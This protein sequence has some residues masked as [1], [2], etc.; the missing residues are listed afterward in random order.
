[1]EAVI[2]GNPNSGSA[3]DEGYLEHF[4]GI[5]REG[6]LQV[7]VLNTEHPDHATELAASSSDKLVIAA[8]GDGTINEV[9]NGL[10]TGATFGVLPLG[11]ANVLA[12][13][14]GLPLDPEQACQTILTGTASRM[15][16]GIATDQEGTERRFALMAG[17]GFDAEVVRAVTP[18]VK[19][20]LRG[21]AYPLMALKVYF[22]S[23]K[24]EL[25]VKVG[26]TN[27][28]TE[29]AVIANG[30]YYGGDFEIAEDTSLRSGNIEVVLI[31][32]V[33]FLLRVDILARILAKKPLD[34]AMRSLTTEKA[35]VVSSA[36]QGT[37]VPVQLDGEVWG[38]LPMSFR[39]E[40]AVINVIR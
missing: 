13:E 17:V 25:S 32:K 27:Y 19:R 35:T 39:V 18:G 2:I 10:S 9:V 4:A 37:Q 12:R 21:L 3:G 29:F 24:P 22:Q 15:D 16:V 31:S 23:K 40:P 5:L 38:A 36:E 33:S 14:L 8:G 26:D 7:R 6:G 34:R 20:W 30:Q 1:M 11:T 28:E